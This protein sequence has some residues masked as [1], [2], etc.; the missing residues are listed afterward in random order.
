MN[1][2]DFIPQAS[3]MFL[4]ETLSVEGIITTDL[5]TIATELYEGFGDSELSV[6][7]MDA[8]EQLHLAYKQGYMSANEG[9]HTDRKPERFEPP[10]KGKQTVVK[11]GYN[12]WQCNTYDGDKWLTGTASNMTEATE[13]LVEQLLS[14]EN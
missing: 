6:L 1:K 12:G 5:C 4:T 7:V 8:A 10:Y 3:G 11:D 9:R 14:L 2:L 13:I